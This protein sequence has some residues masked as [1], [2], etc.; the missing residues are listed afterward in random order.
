MQV[1]MVLTGAHAGKNIVLANREF[2][3]GKHLAVG[4]PHELEALTRYFARTYQAFVEGTPDLKIAQAR[5]AK[6]AGNDGVLNHAEE[7]L[8]GDRADQVQGGVGG[9]AGEVRQ[10]GAASSPGLDPNAAGGT[11]GLVP[12]G[13]G[14]EDAGLH[15]DEVNKIRLMLRKLDP[16]VDDHWSAEGLPS[17][18]TVAQAMNKPDLSR[19]MIDAAAPAFNRDRA[20]ELKEAEDI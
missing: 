17:V 20:R 6:K 10:E 18:E 9:Q 1:V 4:Q 14:H 19:A 3:K 16:K 2:R 8:A 5:D 12:G 15:P 11:P 13:S 7:G